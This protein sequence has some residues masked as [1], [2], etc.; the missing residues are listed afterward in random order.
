M[1]HTTANAESDRLNKNGI[2]LK[3]VL[4]VQGWSQSRGK[5]DCW[6]ILD[7]QS[8]VHRTGDCYSLHEMYYVIASINNEKRVLMRLPA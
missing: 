8:R 5:I 4:A 3:I 1:N 7:R 6:N 2:N